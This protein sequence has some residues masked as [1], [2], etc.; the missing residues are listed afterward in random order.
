[1]PKNRTPDKSMGCGNAI[2]E[3]CKY[4]AAPT[5]PSGLSCGCKSPEAHD[6]MTQ[7]CADLNKKYFPDAVPCH[8]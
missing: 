7:L 2:R 5:G 4:A 1:M 3:R 8:Y 6:K